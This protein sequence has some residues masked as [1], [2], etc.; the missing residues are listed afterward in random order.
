MRARR[1][2]WLLRSTSRVIDGFRVPPVC[3]RDGDHVELKSAEFAALAKLVRL[4]RLAL[5]PKDLF[6]GSNS[7]Q[8][9]IRRFE[10]ARRKIEPAAP[11]GQGSFRSIRDGEEKRYV[12]QPGRGL[13]YCLV[14]RLDEPVVQV[15]L[16]DPRANSARVD[17]RWAPFDLAAFLPQGGLARRAPTIKLVSKPGPVVEGIRVH[18][19]LFAFIGQY[20]RAHVTVSNTA[21]EPKFV[22]HFTLHVG[23]DASR[24]V[25]C[26]PSNRRRLVGSTVHLEPELLP[27]HGRGSVSGSLFFPRPRVLDETAAA[28]RPHVVSLPVAK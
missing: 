5:K 6:E 24:A 18:V 19:R 26:R 4:T 25:R 8:S 2:H 13:R 14:E 10:E 20:V 7:D 28:I 12:F 9:A 11:R 27:V 16:R 1:G 22:S 17:G 21:P 15:A 23:E 3:Y